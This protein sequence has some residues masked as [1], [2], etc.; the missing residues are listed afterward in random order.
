MVLCLV[1]LLWHKAGKGAS[2]GKEIYFVPALHFS[3]CW[4]IFEEAGFFV[5]SLAAAVH[6]ANPRKQVGQPLARVVSSRFGKK[7]ESTLLI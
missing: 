4:S 2:C 7:M 3:D 1:R 6:I 5:P